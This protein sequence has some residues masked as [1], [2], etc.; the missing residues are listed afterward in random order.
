MSIL[1]EGMEM[2]KNCDECPLL[3][4]DGDYDV[5]FVG[6]RRVMWEWKHDRGLKVI[7]PK[8]DWCPLVPVPPHGRLIDADA[9]K[10]WFVE[11]Y[12][13]S[14]DLEIIHFLE[15]LSEEDSTP[16]VIPADKDGEI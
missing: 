2:P 3:T 13:L 16:T 9:L 7:H 14:A 12:D 5:C 6:K 1:I 4:E 8:P 15:I 11:W 10:A